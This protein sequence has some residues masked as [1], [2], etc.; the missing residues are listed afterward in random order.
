[1]SGS[2][3]GRDRYLDLLRSIALV[4]VVAYH[5][6][7][8]ALFSLL[9]PAMG[10][11]FALAGAL[12]ARSL[13]R[14]A[15]GVLRSRARRVLVP[16]WVYAAT[17]LAL[18][19]GQGWSPGA[20]GSWGQVLLWF[21]PVGDPVFPE[22]AGTGTVDPTWPVQAGEILWYVRTYFWFMLLSPV[23]L[24]AFRARPWPVLLAPLA[25]SGLLALGA[26]PL[27]SWADAPVTDAATYGSCWL[28]GFA[29][30]SG[31]LRRAPRGLVLAAGPAAMVLGLWWA[32][33]H[34][35][36]SGWDLNEIPF[37]QALWSF[38]FCAV[39]LRISPSWQELP[40][41]LRF[42]DG[43]V[44]LLNARAMTVYL[45]HNLLLV[46][47]VVLIDVLWSSDLL[48]TAVPGMLES[49]WLSFLLVWPL[50]AAV[51]LAVGWAEDLAAGRRPRLWPVRPAPVR[52][53]PGSPRSAG[54]GR[55]HAAP[56]GPAAAGSAPAGSAAD[57]SAAAGSPAADSAAAG[58][59]PGAPAPVRP[60]GAP[61][62]SGR[63]WLYPRAAREPVPPEALSPRS[64][65]PG[66][67]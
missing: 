12:M 29:H 59:G 42:L 27:P 10:V 11:M 56:A 61:G 47:T 37:A 7:A 62:F 45:W 35:G 54:T 53:V 1:M 3:P 38:G 48:A 51:V 58:T 63:S 8:G 34:L 24:R 60:T 64:P 46:V 55:V 16:L 44:S 2:E 23:L 49:P 50:L 57:G 52:I 17:V 67:G 6:F 13:R 36:G 21:L 15:A 20:D 25:L 9:F 43:V 33:G 31:L 26:V 22:S 18:L 5:T 28:L 66:P 65:G 14:P 30:Q 19:V 41:P 40:R 39:L 4:R 32:A